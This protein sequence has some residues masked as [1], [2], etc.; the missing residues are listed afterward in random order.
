MTQSPTKTITSAANPV[1]KMLKSLS[2]RKYR[3]ESGLFLVEGERPIADA[4]TNGFNLVIL[5]HAGH[6][7]PPAA[8]TAAAREVYGTTGEILR[9]IT[10]RDNAQPVIGVFALPHHTLDYAQSGL[11]VA[12]EA[13]RDPGNLGTIIRTADAAGAAGLI[14]IG[15]CCDAYQPE[16]IRAT[17]GS[18][19]RIPVIRT[20][21]ESF[22]RW[23]NERSFPLTGTHLHARTADY[24]TLSYPA[25]MCLLMGNESKGLSAGLTAAC[26]QLAVIPMAAGPES[27]N[28][29]VSTALMLYEIKRGSL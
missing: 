29:A 27:L 25:T 16:T 6:S 22:L 15:D 2:V 12:L 8:L 21:E 24:R 4:V 18:F 13:I 28:L 5:A 26:D 1:V 19:T 17:M 20:D 10:N 11:W 3:A 23:K 14:L 7:A 9:R